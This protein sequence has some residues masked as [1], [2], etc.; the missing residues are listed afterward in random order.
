MAVT[1]RVQRA[2]PVRRSVAA[3][4]PE[5][6][7]AKTSPLKITGRPAMSRISDRALVRL[8]RLSASLHRSLPL[9]V[10][11]ATSSPEAKPATTVSPLTA[12]LEA[13]RIRAG[14]IRA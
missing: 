11:R 12:G 14:S 10:R 13:D 9:V 2:W 4:T 1:G 7:T 8:A 5:W 6:L 3:K